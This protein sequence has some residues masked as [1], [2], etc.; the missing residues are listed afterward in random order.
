MI[1]PDFCITMARYN[2]WQSGWMMAAV[3]GL[4]EAERQK[5]RGAF[6][7][8]IQNTLSHM[9]WGDEIWMSRFDGGQPPSATLEDS[10][11]A[12]LDWSVL[13]EGR[14]AMD[15]RILDWANALVPTDLNGDLVWFS[16]ASQSEKRKAKAL[17]VMQLFNHQTHHRGQV[18]TMLT[19]IGVQTSPTDL[20][21]MPDHV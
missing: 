8:S 21:F 10:P 14:T 18:H 15:R 1:T 5:P 13:A 16:G 19:S 11:T 6:F 7:G 2:H 20:P 17:C 9:L 12:Y 4:S 3:A